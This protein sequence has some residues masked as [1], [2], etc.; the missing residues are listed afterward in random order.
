VGLHLVQDGYDPLHQLMSE[1]A[2]GRHG[3]A[4][5]IAFLSLAGAVF[6]VQA[7]AG[8]APVLRGLFLAAGLCFVSAGVFTLDRDATMHIASVALAFVL[9]V[10]AIYLFPRL[11]GPTAVIAPPALS[12]PLSAGVAVSVALGHTALPMG[13]GQRLAAGCLLAWLLVVGWRL[14]RG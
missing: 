8:G 1:L 4:M 5:L 3:W 7:A 6:G 11:A 2:L 10:L 12:W 9:S 14:S 13:L